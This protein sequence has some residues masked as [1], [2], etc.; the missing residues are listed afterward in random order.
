MKLSN[1]EPVNNFLINLQSESPEKFKIIELIRKIFI[2]ANDNLSEDIKYGGLVFLLSNSLMGGVFPYKKHTSV[3]FSNG[4]ELPDPLKVLEGNGKKRR[5]VKIFD[6]KDV[7]TKNLS[8]F[9]KET[10]RE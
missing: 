10:M 2:T 6:I 9:I 7:K 1:K 8:F 5:H 4:S 3:E